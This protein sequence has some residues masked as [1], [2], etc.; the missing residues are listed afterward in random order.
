MDSKLRK[1]CIIYSVAII[2][3]LLLL[4][5][6]LNQRQKPGRVDNQKE[7]SSEQN[8]ETEVLPDGQIG[9]D[10]KAFLRDESFFDEIQDGY[11]QMRDDRNRLALIVTSVEKDMRIQIVDAS[12]NIVKGEL[13]QVEVQDKGTYTD[14]N[15]DGM[16]HVENLIAGEYQVSLKE[17]GEYQVKGASLNVKVKD[18]VEYYPI[19]DIS[20][21]IKTEEEVVAENEDTMVLE[22][23][24]D[25][26]ET[27]VTTQRTDHKNG[28]VGIDVSKWNGDIDWEEVADSGIK[29]AIIRAGYR[30]SKTGSLVID[31][32]FEQNMKG[33]GDAGLYRGVYFFTQA[34]NE[35]EAVE[36]ASMVLELLQPY[37]IQYPIFID[38]EGAGGNGR[39]DALS[40]EERTAVCVAFC[41]TIKNAGYEGGVYASRYWYYNNVDVSRLEKFHIWLAEYRKEP[42]YEG[43]YE[44]WQH[45]SKGKVPGIEGNVDMNLSFYKV[46]EK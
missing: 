40:K 36:E 34:T 33:A 21:L 19:K 38:T 4:V 8:V 25:V 22:T 15:R 37:A 28:I 41:N 39:A 3:G 45:S 23:I 27:E 17:I 6:L 44:I 32:Y 2:A 26:D 46:K 10:L 14:E 29:F 11:T 31:P 16:I 42:L 35:V 7:S 20:L 12:G 13:F 9:N 43:Y 1:M 30:G 5:L 24:E 18:K